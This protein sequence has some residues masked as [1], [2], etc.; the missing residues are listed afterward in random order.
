MELANSVM[1]HGARSDHCVDEHPSRQW[2]A[3]TSTKILPEMLKCPIHVAIERGHVK[4]VDLFV[5]QSLLCTQ[6]RDP[7]TG[8]LPYRLALCCFLS[9]KSKEEKQRYNEIYFYLHDK[10]FNL[11]VPLNAN[12]DYV[13]NL[14]TSTVTA[15]AVHRSSAHHVFV[16]LSLYCK[17]IR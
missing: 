13:S 12:G 2:T 7:I 8:Y 17:I 9:A 4:M 1:Q 11:K 3:E 14:L 5:R 6:I 15:T 10:H 16:S